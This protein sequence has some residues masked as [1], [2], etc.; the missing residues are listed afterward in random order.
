M[1][2]TGGILRGRTLATVSGWVTRP[3]S[4]KIRQSIFNIL[5]NDVEGADVLDLFAGSGALGIEALSRGAASAVFVESGRPQAEIVKKNL[6]SLDLTARI[7]TR[8]FRSACQHLSHEGY[9]FDLVFADPPYEQFLPEVVGRA[10]LQYDLLHDKGLFIME[11]KSGP[12]VII[13]GL[14]LLKNRKFGQTEVSFY[15]RSQK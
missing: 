7:I 12:Q 10:V 14:K 4:E 5:M 3:T 6:A 15:A 9:R 11:R 2:I 13:D 8:D 1:R